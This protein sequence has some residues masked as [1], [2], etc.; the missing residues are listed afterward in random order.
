MNKTAWLMRKAMDTIERRRKRLTASVRLIADVAPCVQHAPLHAALW[1][2]HSQCQ[3]PILRATNLWLVKWN[4][5]TLREHIRL[6]SRLEVDRKLSASPFLSYICD[7]WKVVSS[8]K[9]ISL[10]LTGLIVR[11]I[12]TL[13]E[14]RLRPFDIENLAET[15]EE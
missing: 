14:D 1:L 10:N 15:M 4:F 6:Q 5:E 3:K 13:S 7:T 2:W 12:V 11:S 9:R 8:K